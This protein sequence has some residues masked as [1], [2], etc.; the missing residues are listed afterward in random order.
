MVRMVLFLR[1]ETLDVILGRLGEAGCRCGIPPA[2]SAVSS[3]SFFCSLS[4]MRTFQTF[5]RAADQKKE[6]ELVDEIR[7]LEG[8]LTLRSFDQVRLTCRT[9]C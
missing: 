7:A 6:R 3:L 9:C 2:V 8:P 4:N 5:S 1:P